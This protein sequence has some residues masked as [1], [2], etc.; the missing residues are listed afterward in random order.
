MEK[1]LGIVMKKS[2][3]R[4]N[5]FSNRTLL[6]LLALAVVIALIVTVSLLSLKGRVATKITLEAGTK[7][8]ARDLIAHGKKAP[9]IQKGLSEEE[10]RTPGTYTMKVILAPFSYKVKVTVVDTIAPKAETKTVRKFYGGVCTPEDFVTNIEDA[11]EV[12][13]LF[14]DAPDYSLLGEQTVEL[15]LTDRAG[16]ETRLRAKLL[17]ASAVETLTIELGDVIPAPAAYLAAYDTTITDAAVYSALPDEIAGGT[18]LP[19]DYALTILAA[20][21]EIPVVLR[22]NDSLPPE[23]TVTGKKVSGY[24]KKGLTPEA[25]VVSVSDVSEVTCFFEEEPDWSV[26][27]DGTAVIV[28]MDEYGNHTKKTVS[29]TL[30][31]DKKAPEVRVENIDTVIDTAV[32]YKKAI[33]YSD[34]VDRKEELVLTIDNS[35]VDLSTEGSY[36]VIYTVTDTSGN[37]TSMTGKVNV[38]KEMPACYDQDE[39]Y[40]MADQVLAKIIT[41]DMSQREITK[42]IYTWVRKNVG[43]I[44]HSEKG[45]VIR[46]AYEGFKL[47]KGDCYVYASITEVLLTR[48]GIENMMIKQ[49][50]VS[51]CHYWNLV[52]FG[53]GWRHLD[54]VP[55][56]D[57]STFFLTSDEDLWNYSDTHKNTHNY[58]RSLYPEIL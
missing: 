25:F 58:D 54:T 36:D 49:D 33:T 18:M 24:T 9:A 40:R 13:V 20:G 30:K 42:A 3:K 15:L 10:L 22:I 17:Y 8:T 43:Y 57:H 35:R 29:Y 21:C 2:S 34:N 52:N 51:P 4:K 14:S 6:I 32:S 16:N 56:K 55:R 11:T 19:G 41:P 23:L 48:A 7:L 37:A 5:S 38:W 45:D 26:E 47:H 46:S 12:S 50:A 31:S 1:R 27:G 53:D 28:A 44:Q 39:V